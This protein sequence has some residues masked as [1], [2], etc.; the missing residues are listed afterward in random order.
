[1]PT[2]ILANGEEWTSPLYTT[3]VMQ[4]LYS[5]WELAVPN[6]WEPGEI[7]TRIGQIMSGENEKLVCVVIPQ[8]EARTD[9]NHPMPYVLEDR[10]PDD[11]PEGAIITHRG[12]CGPCSTL[13]NLAIY[14]NYNDLTEPVREC[15]ITGFFDREL[16]RLAC[17]A[18]LGFDLPCAQ[19]WDLTVS[20]TQSAC[21]TT[22]GKRDQR[23]G[24]Y[25]TS[26]DC[27]E[28]GFFSGVTEESILNDCLLCDEV[29]SD[30]LFEAA[31]GRTRRGSGLTSAICRPCDRVFRVE[32]DYPIPEDTP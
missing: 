25:N 3:T 1:M 2:C 18:S 19:A 7:D 28:D 21:L 13:K 14:I 6:R 12:R 32:H 27:E 9:A 10:S 11:V 29:F 8:P 16:S 30:E 17:I 23:R 26:Y 15:S 31:A 4:S 5:K 22:C 20:K 24:N